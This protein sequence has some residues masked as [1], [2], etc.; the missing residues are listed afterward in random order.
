VLP[1]VA[2]GL[3]RPGASPV[4][5]RA[6]RC[7]A[8]AALT[9][10]DPLLAFGGF[11]AQISPGLAAP[12]LYRVVVAQSDRRETLLHEI[13]QAVMVRPDRIVAPCETAPVAEE[14][15][16]APPEHRIALDEVET[17]PG[18]AAEG[19]RHLYLRGW[20]WVPALGGADLIELDLVG[21]TASLR[22]RLSRMRRDDVADHLGVPEAAWSGFEALVPCG[23]LPP[24]RY[25]ARL[26]Y[27]AG[28]DAVLLPLDLA[29]DL[30]LPLAA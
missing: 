21:A 9:A 16:R 26:R 10:A 7:R 30:A 12:G 2:L 27:G 18:D 11:R 22:A 4:W 23:A 14:P 17:G 6:A 13:G 20:A 24:G 29:L 3:V 25:A 15:D 28:A 1:G 19:D 8:P 5:I